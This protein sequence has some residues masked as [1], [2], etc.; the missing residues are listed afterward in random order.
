VWHGGARGEPALLASCY[1]NSMRLAA[2]LVVGSI[3]LPAISTGVY[4][5]PVA[6]AAEIAVSAVRAALSHAPSIALVRFVC[7]HADALA[8][9]QRLLDAI[10]D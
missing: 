5:Y 1:T 7:F 2:E 3:A 8:I 10:A 9:Y 4:G 6:E